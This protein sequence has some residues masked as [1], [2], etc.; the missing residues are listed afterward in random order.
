MDEQTNNYKMYSHSN[1]LFF[2]L[3]R[4]SCT[5][6]SI[7]GLIKGLKTR[8]FYWTCTENDPYVEICKQVTQL[9]SK[10]SRNFSSVNLS[11]NVSRCIM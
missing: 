1:A 10:T 8:G 5:K 3:F 6:G 4:E 9:N 2:F 7:L 11:T